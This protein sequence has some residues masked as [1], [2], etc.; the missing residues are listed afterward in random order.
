MFTAFIT[1][2]KYGDAGSSVFVDV[3]ERVDGDDGEDGDDGD[4]GEGI[5]KWNW[6]F[7]DYQTQVVTRGLL[8][9]RSLRRMPTSINQTNLDT[10]TF[11]LI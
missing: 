5:K 6:R 1:L 11:H 2:I 8:I 4:D 9:G 7:L 10:N 3:S